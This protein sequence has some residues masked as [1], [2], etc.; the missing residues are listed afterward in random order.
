M[1]ELS[2][3][4]TCEMHNLLSYPVLRDG[5]NEAV[6]FHGTSAAN[7]E[8]IAEQGFDERFT[9]RAL[10]GKCVYL[11]VDTCK[12]CGVAQLWWSVTTVAGAFLVEKEH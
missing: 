9:K 3:L 10:Y 12:A 1:K 11:T 8:I 6:L 5:A 4:T 7:A 2:T